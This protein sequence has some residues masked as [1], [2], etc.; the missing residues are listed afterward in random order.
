MLT[1]IDIERLKEL[2]KI[3]IDRNMTLRDLVN[4]IINDYLEREQYGA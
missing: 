1:T 4:K 2:K 3:A